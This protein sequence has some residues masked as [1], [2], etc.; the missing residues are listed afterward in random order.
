MV[1]GAALCLS[2]LGLPQQRTT[3]WGLLNHT[4]SSLTFL[5]ARVQ[6]QGTSTVGSRWKPL[7]GVDG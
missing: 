2:P 1:D 3:D 6:G 5:E 4:D 7:L